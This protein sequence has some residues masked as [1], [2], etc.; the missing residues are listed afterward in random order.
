MEKSELLD[1]LQEQYQKWETLIDAIGP[2]R[3][4][5]PGVNRD[6]S[7]KDIAAHL[8]GWNRWL[9]VRLQAAQRGES[10]P[11]PPWPAHLKTDDDIN[12]WIYESHRGRSLRQVLEETQRVHQQLVTVIGELPDDVRIEK[13][14]PAYYLVWVN[15]QRFPASEFF[16][17]FRDDHEPDVRAWLAREEEH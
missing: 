2:A 10:D 15:D 3:M 11:P 8:M 12:A 17:H 9:V 16:D 13:I 14:E 7:M 6:W 4:G 5:E 1:W